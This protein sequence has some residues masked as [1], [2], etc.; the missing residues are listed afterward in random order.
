MG[1]AAQ[2]R[3]ELRHG[4]D[5]APTCEIALSPAW[6]VFRTGGVFVGEASSG[7]STDGAG[8]KA[9]PPLHR[10][11][12]ALA[13][14]GGGRCA[15]MA[16]AQ[17]DVPAE[18]TPAAASQWLAAGAVRGAGPGSVGASKRWTISGD[19]APVGQNGL[20][21]WWWADPVKRLRA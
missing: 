7:C 13:L 11:E 20:D 14:R 6:P 21:V 1:L 3:Q 19:R 18:E 8:V 2:L 15:G 12:C 16:S 17:L 9:L 5:P 10:Q 4:A